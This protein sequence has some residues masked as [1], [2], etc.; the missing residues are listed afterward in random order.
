[1]I[2]RLILPQ[3]ARTRHP[4]NEKIDSTGLPSILF[5]CLS[6][7]DPDNNGILVASC[8]ADSWGPFLKGT[9][10]AWRAGRM[11]FGPS[12]DDLFTAGDEVSRK[13]ERILSKVKVDWLGMKDRYERN[14]LTNDD[15]NAIG[16][17]VNEEDADASG[18]HKALPYDFGFNHLAEVGRPFHGSGNNMF[19]ETSRCWKCRFVH[20][21]DVNAGLSGYIPESTPVIVPGSVALENPRLTSLHANGP[22]L[23][24]ED[25]VHFQCSQLPVIQPVVP[26]PTLPRPV[27]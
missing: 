19:D 6:H 9:L 1:M 2:N 3:R 20:H 4:P 22:L 23:C 16:H 27:V 18:V 11:A 14:L 24:A 10:Q 12:R 26:M 7:T 5:C 15:Y 13:F 17:A 25:L 8:N 21:Y